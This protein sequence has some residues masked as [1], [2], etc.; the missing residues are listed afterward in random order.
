MYP[1]Q[2]MGVSIPR[3]DTDEDLCLHTLTSNE[4]LQKLLRRKLVGSAD[5]DR[6][7]RFK[8]G[9][10]SPNLNK[11]FQSPNFM[12]T[13]TIKQA[14]VVFCVVMHKW[15]IVSVWTKDF[16]KVRL[17]VGFLKVFSC[18]NGQL[19]F[20]FYHSIKSWILLCHSF[21][22][23]FKEETIQ[24]ITAVEATAINTLLERL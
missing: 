4:T 9:V 12:Q 16:S 24:W 20:L 8:D 19:Y 1:L 22:K 5:S 23:G 3:Y 17:N 13:L 18:C 15:L 7:A 21:Q 14:C 2:I 6:V 11:K 10:L